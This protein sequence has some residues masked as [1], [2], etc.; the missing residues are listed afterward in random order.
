MA[1]LKTIN[2][3]SQEIFLSKEC[4]HR[5]LFLSDKT[6]RRPEYYRKCGRLT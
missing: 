4:R 1:S 5:L 2:Q 3:Q 6:A